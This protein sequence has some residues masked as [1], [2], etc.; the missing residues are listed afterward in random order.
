MDTAIR[1]QTLADLLRRTAKRYPHKLGLCCGAT[2][3]MFEGVP[4]YPDAESRRRRSSAPAPRC[5]TCRASPRRR[6]C[7]GITSARR[8]S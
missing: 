6:T 3:I 8:R 2:E 5:R 1:R 4:V 7:S